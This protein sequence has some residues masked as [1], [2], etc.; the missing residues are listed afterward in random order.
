MYMM[1][2][3][4]VLVL[5]TRTTDVEVRGSGKVQVEDVAGE[6]VPGKDHDIEEEAHD[7]RMG[8]ESMRKSAVPNV[9][10]KADR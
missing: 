1:S 9:A 4:V 6:L 8:T 5:G 3:P 7:R 10:W 2:L